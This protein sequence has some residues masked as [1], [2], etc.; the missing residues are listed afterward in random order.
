MSPVLSLSLFL[1]QDYHLLVHCLCNR[2]GYDGRQCNPWHHWQRQR[3]DTR[4][5]DLSCVGFYYIIDILNVCF[6][7]AVFRTYF[8]CT[9]FSSACPSSH[10]VRCP[11]WVSSLLRWAL[12]ASNLVFL[13]LVET[14]LVSIR[15][16]H[17]LLSVNV[18][19]LLFSN[20]WRWHRHCACNYYTQFKYLHCCTRMSSLVLP[21]HFPLYSIIMEAEIPWDTEEPGT[22]YCS[23]GPLFPNPSAPSQSDSCCSSNNNK[24]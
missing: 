5:H 19:A 17:Y 9:F 16:E 7:K 18:S 13:P 3:R 14:S 21:L 8:Y 23:K 1:L 24:L 4:Q 10:A 15:L 22:T 2:P 11:W 12:A 6:W 20:A